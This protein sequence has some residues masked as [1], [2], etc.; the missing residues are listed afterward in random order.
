MRA[1]TSE[2]DIFAIECAD[3]GTEKR[4]RLSSVSFPLLDNH[5]NFDEHLSRDLE[6]LV[7]HH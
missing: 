6:R 4:L 7:L 2:Y 3:E 5:H 1:A